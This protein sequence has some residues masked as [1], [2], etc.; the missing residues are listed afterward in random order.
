[1]DAAAIPPGME[2]K[3]VGR[4]GFGAGAAVFPPGGPVAN[5]ALPGIAAGLGQLSRLRHRPRDPL[6]IAWR[7][8]FIMAA[9]FYG[10]TGGSD[11]IYENRTIALP[12]KKP[13]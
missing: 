1:M 10:N 2:K 11:Y 4:L 9:P 6:C 13:L 8:A 5:L 3:G 12:I 7:M